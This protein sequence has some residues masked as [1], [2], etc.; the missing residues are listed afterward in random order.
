MLGALWRALGLSLPPNRQE[1]GRKFLSG[2]RPLDG[3]ARTGL[4]RAMADAFVRA[5]YVGSLG[6][7]K[8][9][10]VVD[11][12]AAAADHMI[13]SWDHVV[14]RVR[15]A[16]E[17]ASVAD[18]AIRFLR[19][20][21]LDVA[22]RVAAVEALVGCPAPPA[23]LSDDATVPIWVRAG[24]VREQLRTLPAALGTSW[25]RIY[26]TGATSKAKDEWLYRGSR[27]SLASL[28]DLA[29]RLAVH[30]RSAAPAHA[31]HFSLA[32]RFALESLTDALAAVIGRSAMEDIGAEFRRTRKGAHAQL[33]SE[34]RKTPE[35]HELIISGAH[36]LGAHLLIE[37]LAKSDRQALVQAVERYVHGEELSVLG[38]AADI[39][40]RQWVRDLRG[41]RADWALRQ[42]VASITP[43]RVAPERV[44]LE[45]LLSMVT[46]LAAGDLHALTTVC[47]Q[48]PAARLWIL[49]ASVQE[50]L[51]RG[52]YPL[53]AVLLPTISQVAEILNSP[54]WHHDAGLLSM[55]VGDYARALRHFEQV[56]LVPQW[57]PV[58]SAM[59]AGL[60][61]LT[62]SPADAIETLEAVRGQNL[63]LDYLRG[64][65]LRDLGRVV[66]ALGAFEEILAV[67]P[68]HLHA[69]EQAALCAY[70]LHRRV[71]GNRY[72]RS[73]RRLGSLVCA[74]PRPAHPRR[75][76]RR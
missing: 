47:E 3:D 24:E 22:I 76:P 57:A 8:A 69:L 65:A 67:E 51:I 41:C 18:A 33:A 62:G 16:G 14:G 10:V 19:V 68:G 26:A 54:E 75:R 27:P 34:R 35:L 71:V 30:D 74:V 9:R 72:A 58:A 23:A 32:W 55:V 64:I 42:F 31:W 21:S 28:K 44:P 49:R 20:A 4:L 1:T 2:Q 6:E 37:Q 70:A 66:D 48:H 45:M 38:E 63:W 56:A 59:V 15:A 53:L 11:L 40:R 5:G 73:A 12:L 43:D 50:A 7:E 60:K 36:A 17:P 13:A 29:R 61:V 52:L 46:A 39:R 25:E